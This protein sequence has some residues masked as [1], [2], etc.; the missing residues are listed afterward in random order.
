MHLMANRSRVL[1]VDDNEDVI[2]MLGVVLQL[3]GYEIATARDGATALHVARDFAPQIA[4][5]DIALETA[6]DGYALAGQL[7]ELEGAIKL[8]AVTGYARDSD[9]ARAF[10]AGFDAHVVK[11]VDPDV[12]VTLLAKL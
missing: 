6:D 2:E 9:R 3:A 5:L 10:N 11:P 1:V 12:L 8:V 4:L 7:K